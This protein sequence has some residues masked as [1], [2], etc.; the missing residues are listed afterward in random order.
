MVEITKVMSIARSRADVWSG[1]ADFGGIER[2][3]PNVDHSSMTTGQPVG[4]GSVRRVQV[5]RNALLETVVVWEPE[6]CLSYSLEGLPPVV[7]SVT[8]IWTLDGDNTST[9]ATTVTLRTRIDAG[10]RPPQQLVGRIFGK[11]LA[12]A[13]D[14]M[15][16]GL[17]AHLEEGRP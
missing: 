7:R 17:K 14:E 15:L 12:K 10:P 8:N 6:H 13:S 2:W 9:T 16:G 11:V 5:G 3:A 1:L 4:L